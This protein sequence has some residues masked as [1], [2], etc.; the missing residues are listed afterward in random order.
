MLNLPLPSIMTLPLTKFERKD[1]WGF[2]VTQPG[3]QT[4]PTTE[5]ITFKLMHDDKEKG[6]DVVMQELLGRLCGR[7]STELRGLY[8]HPFGRHDEQGEVVVYDDAT[9]E[10]IMLVRLHLQDLESLVR[11]LDTDRTNVMLSNDEL[12]VQLREKD[13]AFAEQDEIIKEM[14]AR[15][16]SQDK[17]FKNQEKRVQYRN[18]KIKDMKAEIEAKDFKLET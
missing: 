15:F 4:E 7:H 8:F 12:Q 18:K 6:L 13:K 17:K 16:E 1:L 3:R 5:T 2:R 14:E 10:A 11:H 9:R